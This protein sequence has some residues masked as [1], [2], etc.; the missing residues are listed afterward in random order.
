M[1]V[2]VLT[3]SPRA[4]ALLIPD[5]SLVHFQQVPNTPSPPFVHSDIGMKVHC[6]SFKKLSSAPYAFETAES[7]E[8]AP[9]GSTFRCSVGHERG[10]GCQYDRRFGPLCWQNDNRADSDHWLSSF[11]LSVP[12]PG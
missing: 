8:E 5:G 2:S 11:R 1:S 4:F 10:V 12:M 9:R 3:A 7:V 6:T